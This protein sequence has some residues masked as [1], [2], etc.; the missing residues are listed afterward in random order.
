[1]NKTIKVSNLVYEMLILLAK[2]SN[3]NPNVFTEEL[4]QSQ[5][6]NLK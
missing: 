2:K 3:R 6:K 5:Y 4:I 1:M